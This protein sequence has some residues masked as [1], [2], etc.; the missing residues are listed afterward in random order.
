V[1]QYE[2]VGTDD[3]GLISEDATPIPGKRGFKFML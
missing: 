2:M 3:E 1:V